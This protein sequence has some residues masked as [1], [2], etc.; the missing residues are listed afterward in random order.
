MS[1]SAPPPANANNDPWDDDDWDGAA[2]SYKTVSDAD[3]AQALNRQ[4]IQ[5]PLVI[6]ETAF[7]AS[8]A[9]LIWLINFYVPAGPL[10]RIFFPIPVA[11]IHL[12]WHRRAAWM[13]AIVSALL[14]SVLMGPPRSLQYLLP[15]GVMGVILGGLWKKK[16]TW[17]ISL[18]WG[19]VLGSIGFF[20]QITV[21]S[22]LLGEN[23][24][25]YVNQ[26]VTSFLD[27][28]LV[29]LGILL[30]P[31][32][33]MIQATAVVLVFFQSFVY[34][35]IVHILAWRLLGRLGNPIPDPPRWLEDLLID[36]E[37]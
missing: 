21:V 5:R 27:W 23:L 1:S 33:G 24:W 10:L 6:T 3:Y 17:N 28:V 29:Q 15:H 34:A 16:V 30:V 31:T 14:L 12:R 11:L 32:V 2:P 19:A 26:Q 20:F 18:L 9:A 7:L 25:I 22:F 8:A 4:Q 13:G 37:I 35:L 36:R